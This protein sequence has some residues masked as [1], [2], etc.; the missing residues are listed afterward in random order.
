MRID[1]PDWPDALRDGLVGRHGTPRSCTRLPGLSRNRVWRVT[2]D[3]IAFVVKASP[4]GVEAAFYGS[5]APVVF[6]P[7]GAVPGFV[8]AW[9][10]VRG[11]G[12]T[13]WIVLESIPHPLPRSRWQADPGVIAVLERLHAAA[14]EPLEIELFVPSWSEERNE[15]V[16][17]F[18]P[19]EVR[20][21]VGPALARM[22]REA[23]P[24][25]EPEGWISGDPNPRNWGLRDDGSL[26]LFDWERFGLGAPELDL[27]ITLPGLGEREAFARLGR[28]CG[29]DPRRIAVAKAWSVAEFLDLAATGR[30]GDTRAVPTLV[31]ALPDWLDS[32]AGSGSGSGSGRGTGA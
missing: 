31:R 11:S 30:L 21:R 3:G 9:G 4:S 13:T 18:L 17:A 22:R 5:V 23:E 16:L 20:H 12:A 19:A 26:V 2:F 7:G 1:E 15:R 10:P 8:A 29:R 28:A 32:L 25:F 27:A 14:P 24:L 6:G